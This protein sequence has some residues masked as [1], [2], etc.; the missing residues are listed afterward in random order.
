MATSTVGPAPNIPGEAQRMSGLRR[1][2]ELFTLRGG[3]KQ[4]R[5]KLGKGPKAHFGQTGE[6][7]KVVCL[8]D[9]FDIIWKA[10]HVNGHLKTPR[11]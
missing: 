3:R 7:P 5:R 4:L 10:H 9:L 2:W 8:D 6:W 1:K 11:H